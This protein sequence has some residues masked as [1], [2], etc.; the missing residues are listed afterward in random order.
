[1]S[2]AVAD[3]SFNAKNFDNVLIIYHNLSLPEKT[4]NE[5]KQ[6]LDNTFKKHN[7]NSSGVIY[8]VMDK[9]REYLLA[10]TL[11]T[12]HSDYILEIKHY[13]ASYFQ[14]SLLDA[15]TKKEIWKTFTSNI[16]DVDKINK[17]F[18]KEYFG[19]K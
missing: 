3:T 7:I 1:M 11:T 10:K 5:L 6:E 14:W 9:E 19:K 4:V 15:N 18:E 8:S 17:T 2:R 16:T 12:F 13:S